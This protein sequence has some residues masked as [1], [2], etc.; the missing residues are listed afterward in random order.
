MK[1][2]FASIKSEI[3]ELFSTTAPVV[4]VK[5]V[6]LAARKKAV[7]AAIDRGILRN[8]GDYGSAVQT[9]LAVAGRLR[10]QINEC[11]ILHSYPAFDMIER[12]AIKFERVGHC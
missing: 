12:A 11:Y 8:H 5:V 9:K 4:E 6:S 10:R 7:D 3:L 1:K 2:L